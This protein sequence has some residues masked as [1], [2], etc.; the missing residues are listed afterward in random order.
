[1]GSASP[2]RVCVVAGADPGPRCCNC[3]SK[4]VSR[5]G[6]GRESAK[7]TRVYPAPTP[8]LP[9]AASFTWSIFIT[10]IGF[11][12]DHARIQRRA[13]QSWVRL[14]PKPR[15]V[16]VGKGEGYREVAKEFGLE[17]NPNLDMNFVGMP[18]AGSVV[19][20]AM[21]SHT[22]VSVIIN[23]DILL[24]QS[25]PDAIARLRRQFPDWFLAGARYAATD[26]AP[27]VPTVATAALASTVLTCSVCRSDN[28]E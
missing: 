16:L 7:L 13:I 27:G 8:L 18:L 12:G 2:P 17:I 6:P 9:R 25:F 15:I 5:L 22:D 20:T 4:L 19:H 14:H 28:A 26:R 23:S 10:P 3:F 21:Q 24:T 1:M 11:V